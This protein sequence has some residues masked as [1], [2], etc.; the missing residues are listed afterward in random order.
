MSTTLTSQQT[1]TV[2]AGDFLS[3]IA[4]RFYGDGSE[5]AWRKIYDANRT[6]IGPDPTQLQVGM[7]LV[8]PAKNGNPPP[9]SKGN[10]QA[11]LKALGEFES[12]KRDGDPEQY[13]VE[14]SLGFIGKY[15]FGEALLKD[16][17]YYQ[18]DPV[19]NGGGNGVAKNFWKGTWT[20]KRGV[21]SK[22]AF[23]NASQVQ[24]AA[25]LEAF[26]LNWT[27]INED[28][29]QQGK[30]VNG[31]L[32]QV[33]TFNDHGTPK[34]VTISLSGLLAGAHLR[35]PYGVA[36]LLLEG[37]VS[38]DEFKTSILKYVDVYGGYAITPTD[39]T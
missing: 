25:I 26:R 30:S 7:V 10:L 1:Y 16:L 32:N 27:R 6:V 33:M 20:N 14:N 35:G 31:Y 15:Q 13:R 22:A 9:N 38:V 4:Q 2:Q 39:F 18:A 5:A 21:G 34:T 3:A 8:I 11:M 12:G 36:K 28:L 19:Y 17:G 23:Q 37:T 24:E 29:A